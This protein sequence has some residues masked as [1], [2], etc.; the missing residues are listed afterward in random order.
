[1]TCSRSLYISE[2]SLL[3]HHT[4]FR[5]CTVFTNLKHAYECRDR[6]K[7]RKQS[8]FG[9]GDFG[10]DEQLLCVHDTAQVEVFVKGVTCELLKQS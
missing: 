2:S 8:N 3:I 7:A 1:M 5:R 6:V 10:I 4:E 9:Y